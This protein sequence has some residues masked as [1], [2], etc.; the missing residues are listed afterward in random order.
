MT[1][2]SLVTVT[3][4]TPA[5]FAVTVTGQSMVI[6]PTGLRPVNVTLVTPARQNQVTVTGRAVL[7]WCQL[8][9]ASD[10]HRRHASHVCGDSHWPIGFTVNQEMERDNHEG[11]KTRRIHKEFLWCVFVP[12]CLGV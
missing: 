1:G 6:Y 7:G 11:T 5:A 2:P 10:G 8:G 12:L 4:V 9:V 3:S